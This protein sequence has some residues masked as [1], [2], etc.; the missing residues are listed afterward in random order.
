MDQS[1][2]FI[3]EAGRYKKDSKK[4]VDNVASPE[5]V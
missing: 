2:R 3:L 1:I 4:L 5:D